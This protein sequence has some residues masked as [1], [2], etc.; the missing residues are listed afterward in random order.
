LS[1][2]ALRRHFI[3]ELKMTDSQTLVM[4]YVRTGSEPAF[5]ELVA[6]YIDLVYSAALRL[7]GRD[8]H[9]AE[10]VSQTVFLNLAR[11]AHRL[12]REVM[13]G[14]W[15]HRDTCYAARALMRSERRRQ[16]RERQAMEMSALEDHS[17]VNLAQLTPL[18]D[19]AIEELR[20]EDR[21]AILLRFFEQ[22]D[23]RAIG[24]ALGSNE[25]AA[26]K[27]VTRAVEKLHGL[28]KGRGVSLSAAALGTVLAT[29]TIIAAPV[30]L[31]ASLA[32]TAL[33]GAAAGAG[34]SATLIKLATMTKIQAGVLGAVVLIGTAATV[35]V[36]QQ[37]RAALRAQ[38]ESLRR[39]SAELARQQ[40]ENERLAGLA[41]PGGPRVNTLDD[42]VNLR[43]EVES[44]RQQTNSLA[45][46]LEKMGRLRARTSPP[47]A[48]SL[49]TLDAMEEDRTW[50]IGGM[51]Y[52]KQWLLAFHLFASDNRDQFPTS[53]EEAQSF[54]PKEA[55]AQTNF[56]TGQF[57]ILY[58]GAITNITAPALTVVLRQKEARRNSSGNWS[59]TYGFADGHSEV[60]S[61]PDGNYGPWE[62]RHIVA[63]P[64]DQ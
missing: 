37:A 28:L 17:Q 9:F 14:G 34:F 62:K 6:R 7:V 32:G 36:Q 58:Q 53:F 24:Q 40:V 52:A 20:A 31:A 35:V 22:R 5:R 11:K 25:E 47:P 12:P 26:R 18:L 33:A 3:S 44:L 4:E 57:E 29:Q 15:L 51:N 43:S 27:R 60:A 63:P 55:T 61:S 2:L 64:P 49:A 30:G 13:L 59:R 16:Q 23:F 19:E 54:L 48:E 10:D 8:A 38:D 50:A 56:T 41:Q 39:Q 45:A 1:G 46:R 21:T 42:L